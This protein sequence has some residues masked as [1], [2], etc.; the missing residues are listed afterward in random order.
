M[1]HPSVFLLF[2]Y[3]SL[4]G[5]FQNPAYEYISSYFEPAGTGR[6]K[7]L[8]AD[9]GDFP[10][11]VPATEEKY[12]IGEIYRLR[13]PAQF[14]WAFGQLDDYEGV[15]VEADEA[16]MYRREVT[17]VYPNDGA[18]TEAWIYWYNGSVAGRPVIASGDVFEYLKN[19]IS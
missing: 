19:K 13:E 7:G 18:A 2:V 14:S 3:G 10:A 15:V 5:G 4:R 12:I 8:L 11:A 6:V 9:L 1:S 16:Q 17:T